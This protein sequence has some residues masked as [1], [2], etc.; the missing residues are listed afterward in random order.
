MRFYLLLCPLAD[1]AC[2]VDHIFD[3]C[4]NPESPHFLWHAD[5]PQE[6][7]QDFYPRE[8]VT[9]ILDNGE[10]LNGI[11]RK[12]QSLLN[13]SNQTVLWNAKPL[14]GTLSA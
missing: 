5:H 14:P 3:V 12:R 4:R 2:L 10:R 11:V 6:F 1:G 9:V 8:T 13:Y 7:K